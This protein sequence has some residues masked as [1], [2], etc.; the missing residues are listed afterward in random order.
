MPTDT[1]LILSL[2]AASLG[3]GCPP[4]E[5]TSTTLTASSGGTTAP[6]DTSSGDAS[7]V[8]PTSSTT[9]PATSSTSGTTAPDLPGPVH[10]GEGGNFIGSLDCEPGELCLEMFGGDTCTVELSCR[11]IPEGCTSGDLCA[12]ECADLCGNYNCARPGECAVN[13]YD[14]G[15]DCSSQKTCK[16]PGTA[17]KP[18]N[19]GEESPINHC[20]P[21]P[22]PGAAIG[23]P[24]AQVG[25]GKWSWDSCAPGGI[26]WPLDPDTLE[27]TCQPQCGLSDSEACALCVEI[28]VTN[29]FITEPIAVCATPCDPLAPACETSEICAP[30][31]GDFICVAD[32]SGDA[33]ALYDPCTAF[34]ECDPGLVCANSTNA[35]LNCDP[36]VIGC[37]VALCDTG[38]PDCP[39]ALSCQPFYQ[40]GQAPAG[41]EALGY[42][43]VMP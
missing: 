23:E 1:W 35:P 15:Y 42:C 29:D 12:A 25:D 4:G 13:A 24:C 5:S 14:C 26:C 17:C 21:T 30:A 27:G 19:L 10:C 28:A 11:P 22:A 31:G 34:N 39:D 16:L 18:I 20:V 41:L 3:L 7:G 33:G 36:E 9:S 32:G 40:P 8:A 38:L 6:G 43:R 2:L 37:C